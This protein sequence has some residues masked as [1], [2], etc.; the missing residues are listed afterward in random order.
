METTSSLP[1]DSLPRAL[2]LVQMLIPNGKPLNEGIYLNGDPDP[3]HTKDQLLA[4][5]H[6]AST[7]E[8]AKLIC[9]MATAIAHS[10]NSTIA[11]DGTPPLTWPH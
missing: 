1:D 10:S 3:I 11:N 6:R 7:E 9:C 5:I 2:E 4:R 8:R